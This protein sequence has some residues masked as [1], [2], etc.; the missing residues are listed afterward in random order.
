MN[1]VCRQFWCGLW[2][3]LLVSP[4]CTY[5]RKYAKNNR[6]GPLELEIHQQKLLLIKGKETFSRLKSKNLA[7]AVSC[8]PKAQKIAKQIEEHRVNIIDANFWI[9][10]AVVLGVL[11][12]TA[13]VMGALLTERK[14]FWAG[15]GVTGLSIGIGTVVLL[16]TRGEHHHIRAKLIDIFN[17]YND[18]SPH[19]KACQKP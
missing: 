9:P 6:S 11:G 3:I 14:T 18:E 12:G 15:L 13:T 1:T 19:T 5:Q 7:K 4:G 16:R 17:V 2:V 10:S 8:V